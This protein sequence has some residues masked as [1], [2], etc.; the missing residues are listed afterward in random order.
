V[1]CLR[2]DKHIEL[3]KYEEGEQPIFMLELEKKGE[4]SMTDVSMN[5]E[6]SVIVISDPV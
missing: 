3:W 5:S 4:L 6:G 1:F 2:K